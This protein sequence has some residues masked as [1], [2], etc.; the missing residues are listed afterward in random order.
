MHLFFKG[1]WTEKSCDG[2]IS[3]SPWEVRTVCCRWRWHS[4]VAGRPAGFS[5]RRTVFIIR[6]AYMGFLVDE[7]IFSFY[8]LSND[9]VN[10]E[11][12][13]FGDEMIHECGAVGRQKICRGNQCT[14]RKPACMPLCER[15]V[16]HALIWDR[17]RTAAVGSFFIESW[18]YA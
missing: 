18:Y 3:R 15:E 17:T 1:N 7:L 2:D 11:S 6:V 12:I 14:Q 10:I 8:W 5:P 9:A 4:S 16:Q 13:C